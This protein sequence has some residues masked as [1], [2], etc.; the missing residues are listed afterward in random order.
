VSKTEKF[1]KFF[2][3]M[4]GCQLAGVAGSFFTV[5]SLNN[6][7]L[8]L[9]KPSL[10]PPGWIFGPVWITLYAMMGVSIFLVWRSGLENKAN[11]NAALLFVI[12]L[13]VNT[14]WS[15]VFFAF[16]QVLLSV[17]VII[18]L[19]FLILACILRFRPISKT[20]SYLLIPYLLWVSFASYLVISIYFLNR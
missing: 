3:S 14:S 10:N 20:A 7:Y 2:L 18:I 5:V 19:W 11:R 17:F 9:S 15:I 12:Q 4:I 1:L 8:E 13:I 6:W 16:Q